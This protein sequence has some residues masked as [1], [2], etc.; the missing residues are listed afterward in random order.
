VVKNHHNSSASVQA[1]TRASSL[2]RLLNKHSVISMHIWIVGESLETA[3]SRLERVLKGS[4]LNES[5]VVVC[6]RLLLFSLSFSLSLSRSLW[7]S[8]V[9]Q[10]LRYAKALLQLVRVPS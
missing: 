1:S 2:I 9:R 6:A 7:D 5:Y 4:E 10:T 8:T 3:F